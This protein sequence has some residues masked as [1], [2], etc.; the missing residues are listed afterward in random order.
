MNEFKALQADSDDCELAIRFDKH[1]AKMKVRC[2]CNNGL[3]HTGSSHTSC[4]SC[5]QPDPGGQSRAVNLLCLSSKV[6]A[7]M[8]QLLKKGAV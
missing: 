4:M 1:S 7:K 3:R 5:A 8:S 6:L 2:R